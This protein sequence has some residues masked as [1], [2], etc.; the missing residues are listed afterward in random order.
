[1]SNEKFYKVSI[2]ALPLIHSAILRDRIKL[3]EYIPEDIKDEM[4]A[5]TR[6]QILQKL[7]NA[8]GVSDIREVL[9]KEEKEKYAV[10]VHTYHG[11]RFR[12]KPLEDYEKYPIFSF[13]P[14]MFSYKM[15]IGL[16]E[17]L[18][19][20]EYPNEDFRIVWDGVIVLIAGTSPINKVPSGISD[21]AEKISSIVSEPRKIICMRVGLGL[22]KNIVFV[23]DLGIKG[24]RK[25][26]FLIDFGDP[27]DIDSNLKT[28]YLTLYSFA[29]SL[30]DLGVHL[31]ELWDFAR[32][33]NEIQENIF[34]KI[35]K[36][37]RLSSWNV[38]AKNTLINDIEK[39]LVKAFTR[40]TEFTR[41][42][43]IYARSKHNALQGPLAWKEFVEV[44]R[45]D[46]VETYESPSFNEQMFHWT[47]D[48]VQGI[49]ERFSLNR[50]NVIAG[51]LG[52]VIVFV[53]TQ[54]INYLIPVLN[55]LRN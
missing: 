55:T 6:N 24:A 16:Q 34:K 4:I 18:S 9:S 49:F 21:V 47:L 31:D 37:I 33:L 25:W 39:M 3:D 1:M 14:I 17:S 10:W 46:L 20:V 36:Y 40:Y 38:L 45:D 27:N 50:S 42:K 52:G 26:D 28:L 53:L 8:K 35:N 22:R 30:Y 43:D 32:E 2:F 29:N 13:E 7:N 5:E 51:A 11:E 48:K 23:P 12:R 54:V 44:F 41:S 15:P 19:P